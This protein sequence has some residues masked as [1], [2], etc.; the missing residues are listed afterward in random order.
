MTQIFEI[1]PNRNLHMEFAQIEIYILHNCGT[2]HQPYV[3]LH[4]GYLKL[5]SV[6]IDIS[7]LEGKKG[8]FYFAKGLFGFSP[9]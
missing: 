4:K 9:V 5:D 3:L 8:I 7:L 2:F 1:Y 6:E